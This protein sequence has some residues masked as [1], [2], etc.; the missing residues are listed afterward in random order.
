MRLLRHLYHNAI[1][2]RT[3]SMQFPNYTEGE[4][5]ARLAD[6]KA[7][8]RKLDQQLDEIVEQHFLD[9]LKVKRLKKRKLALKDFIAGI[10]NA[11][12]P[13]QPA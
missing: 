12:I 1:N 4:L 11:L 6:L 13:D 5:R 10:E 9:D 7:E 3:P 8:H 2:F